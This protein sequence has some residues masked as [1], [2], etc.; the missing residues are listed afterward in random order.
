MKLCN[1][2]PP[3]PIT[4][5]GCHYVL[6]KEFHITVDTN[7]TVYRNIVAALFGVKVDVI[8][9]LWN[10]MVL[11]GHIGDGHK[12]KYLLWALN[13]LKTYNTYLVMS[14]THGVAPNTYIKW[15]WESLRGICGI[16]I[17]SRLSTYFYIF[18][19]QSNPPVLNLL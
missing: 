17:V 15:V 9:P 12:F 6:K 3:M 2:S 16:R 1:L 13:F 19:I 18:V 8:V 14:T 4:S 10:E 11:H 7:S 5:D